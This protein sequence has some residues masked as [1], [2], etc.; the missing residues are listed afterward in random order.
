MQSDKLIH[1]TD[2][3][4]KIWFG[5]MRPKRAAFISQFKGLTKIKQAPKNTACKISYTKTSVKLCCVT[6]TAVRL[7]LYDIE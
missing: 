7:W 5:E 4:Q 6:V 3:H 1:T 2:R